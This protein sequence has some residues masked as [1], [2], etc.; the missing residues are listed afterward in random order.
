MI[1]YI[2]ENMPSLLAKG[3]NILQTPMNFKLKEDI[4]VRSIK[5]EFGIGVQ[6]E[7]WIPIAG[8]KGSC[9]ITQDYNIRRI[10]HQKALCEEFSL[11]MFYFRPPSKKGFSYWNM[12]S[13]L[14]KHWPELTKIALTRKRPF[15]YKVSSRGKLEELV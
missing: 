10:R 11:G 3:F 6:D 14:V 15:A 1:V 5:E 9:I 2:D 13:L 7:E 12:L 8:E 4:E